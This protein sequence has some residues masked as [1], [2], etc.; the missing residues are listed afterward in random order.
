MIW[1]LRSSL[2]NEIPDSTKNLL[3]K[4]RLIYANEEWILSE[5]DGNVVLLKQR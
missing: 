5:Y 4:E 2:H 1:E 3:T